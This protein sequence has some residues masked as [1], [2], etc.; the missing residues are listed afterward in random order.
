L[1][2]AIARTA[3]ALTRLRGAETLSDP[4]V[5][6]GLS[7]Y[8]NWIPAEADSPDTRRHIARIVDT[9]VVA[10]NTMTLA[11]HADFE[12]TSACDDTTG[13]RVSEGSRKTGQHDS[14]VEICQAWTRA[15]N[16]HFAVASGLDEARA[17]ALLHEFVHKSGA[18]ADEKDRF[19]VGRDDW[20]KLGA[21]DTLGYADGYTALAWTLGKGGEGEP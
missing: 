18:F 7:R 8:M 4:A 6:G 21:Q 1:E 9:L 10:Q 14:G 2:V 12:C 11:Q 5:R 17:Y 16:L 3:Q 19:Y 13:A 15:T 20:G